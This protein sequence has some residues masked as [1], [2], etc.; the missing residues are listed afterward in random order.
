[1]TNTQKSQLLHY[2]AVELA[3]TPP[4]EIEKLIK[5]RQR[6]KDYIADCLEGTDAGSFIERVKRQ[7]VRAEFNMTEFMELVEHISNDTKTLES[8]YV[9]YGTY[10]HRGLLKY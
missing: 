2:F 3:H 5:N 8:F 1:M 4:G 9:F 10:G 7:W 6:L